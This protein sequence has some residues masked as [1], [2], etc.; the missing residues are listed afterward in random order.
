MQHRKLAPS[1]MFVLD[2]RMTID[3]SVIWTGDIWPQ[4]RDS[5]PIDV[6]DDERSFGKALLISALRQT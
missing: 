2:G 3:H 1:S 5:P 6:A 4:S